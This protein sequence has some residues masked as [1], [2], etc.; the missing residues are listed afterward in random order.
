MDTV[1]QGSL[2]GA[3]GVYH[4]NLMDSV[5]RWERVGTVEAISE[6]FLLPVLKDLPRSFP[7]HMHPGLPRRQR[8]GAHQP[9]CRR[10]AAQAACGRVRQVAAAARQRQRAGRGQKR[11]GG[12]QVARPR[13]YSAP[14]RRSRQPCPT[15]HEPEE[16]PAFQRD[17]SLWREVRD[18]RRMIVTL[19][20]ERVRALEDAR[21][22]LTGGE[23][24]D[25]DGVDRGATYDLVRRALV[26]LDCERLGKR[27]TGIPARA[28]IRHANR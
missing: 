17:M 16:S 18:H 8:F 3:K 27:D 19:Q 21:A 28:R 24:L 20:T 22:F 23:A 26:R 2:D 15:R 13:P 4:I 12:A 9:Q 5:T 1:R 6:R 14:F 7:V 10:S 25:F 11:G